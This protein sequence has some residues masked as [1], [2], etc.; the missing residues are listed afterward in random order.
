MQWRR[1]ASVIV[2]IVSVLCALIAPTAVAYADGDVQL[3]RLNGRS[4]FIPK[5]WFAGGG[6]SAERA[7]DG[8][9][10]KGYWQKP[11][12]EPIDATGFGFIY[13]DKNSAI[14]RDWTDPLP[15]LIRISTYRDTPTDAARLLP[16]TK[17]F[18][19]VA[20]SQAADADGFVRVSVGFAKP[21][22]QPATEKFLY[23]GYLNKIGQPLIIFS[24]NVETPFADH[25]SS[26]VIIA[27]EHDLSLRFSFSN[28]KFPE[29][30]WFGLYQHTI[31]FVDYMQKSK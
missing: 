26:D 15:S 24:N 23:K 25:Y 19:E 20:A 2:F 8:G 11:Q 18:L 4:F 16:E 9:S 27:L 7:T 22:Q 10:T 17:K 31:A 1:N 5:P 12:S 13:P 28:V 14:A 21:E 29:S 6:I 30:T 3:I